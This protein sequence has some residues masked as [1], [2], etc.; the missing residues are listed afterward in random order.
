MRQKMKS[1]IVYANLPIKSK[2]VGRDA[3]NRSVSER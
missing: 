1:M 2:Q 3:C